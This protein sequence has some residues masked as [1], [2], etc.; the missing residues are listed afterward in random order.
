[1]CNRVIAQIRLRA[2]CFVMLS[3]GGLTQAAELSISPLRVGLAPDQL[4]GNVAIVNHGS[5]PIA[6]QVEAFAWTQ[7]GGLDLHNETEAVLAVPPI[8]ELAPGE[9]QLIRVGLLVPRDALDEAAYRLMLTELKPPKVSSDKRG[10]RMRT[11]VSIP[12]FVSPEAETRQTLELDGFVIIDGM[13]HFRLNNLGNTHVRLERLQLLG[14]GGRETGSVQDLATYLLPRV[15][16]EF[17]LRM[18]SDGRVGMVR[19]RTSAIERIDFPTPDY[20]VKVIDEPIAGDTLTAVGKSM[21]SRN[22]W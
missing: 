15:S 1:M 13:A 20:W 6:M 7:D 22:V 19:V 5:E 8:F 3:C 4:S 16:R 17:V 18:P 10:L 21:R 14:E 11:R 2:L 9:T 12:V